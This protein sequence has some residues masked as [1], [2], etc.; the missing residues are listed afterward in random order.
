MIFDLWPRVV[1]KLG[2]ERHVCELEKLMFA[3]VVEIEKAT[4]LSYAEWME[5]LQRHS[6]FAIAALLHVLRKRDGMPSDFKTMNF[7]A[8]DLKVRPLRDDGTEFTDEEAVADLARREEEARTAK[9]NGAGPT[10]AADG[11]GNPSGEPRSTPRQLTSPS[12][13]ASTE[14]GRGNG[15]GSRTGTGLS[16]RRTRTGS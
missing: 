16:S 5:Q 14:S 11:P 15:N 8:F 1:I 3:D 9:A 6:I 13:P 7:A 2:D 4:G 10:R 12:L